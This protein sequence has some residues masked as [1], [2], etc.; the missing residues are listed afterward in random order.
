LNTLK[1][2]TIASDDTSRLIT[3]VL[4]TM[5]GRWLLLNLP[6]REIG[7]SSVL[8]RPDRV[9]KWTKRAKGRR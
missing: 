9:I 1:S 5:N 6:V 8:F 3:S 4:L 7:A 2:F